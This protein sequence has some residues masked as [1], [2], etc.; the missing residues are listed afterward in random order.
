MKFDKPSIILVR[1]Q[2]PEN[3]GMVARAMDNCGLQNLILVSPREKWPNNLSLKTSAN[4][5]KIIDKTIVYESLKDALSDF[6]FIVATSS[7]KRFLQKTC[8]DN[9]TDLFNVFPIKKKTGIMFGPEN[10]GLSNSDLMLADIIFKINSSKSNTSLNISHA[11]LLMCFKWREFFVLEQ[12]K[13]I[14][15]EFTNKQALKKDFSK[16]INFLK[17]EL[18]EVNF[19]FPKNKRKSI[20]EN[21]QTIFMRSSLSK[22]EIQTLWGMIKKLRK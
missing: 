17:D 2:L 12:K 3:I 4:S 22:T 1:P 16:F 5:R 21:I 14:N 7:R 11:V 8:E 18:I 20:F 9:F 13:S 10:S 15:N 19:L 6:N